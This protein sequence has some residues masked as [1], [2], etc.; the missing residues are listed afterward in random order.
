MKNIIRENSIVFLGLGNPGRDVRSP[1][2]IGAHVCAKITD[3]LMQEEKT[4]M[5]IEKTI[6]GE[7][8]VFLWNIDYANLT[9]NKLVKFFSTQETLRNIP[10]VV[11]C[12]DIDIKP[13]KWVMS[14]GNNSHK[15]HNGIKNINIYKRNYL[16][17]RIGTGRPANEEDVYQFVLEKLNP[18][19]WALVEDAIDDIIL[20]LPKLILESKNLVKG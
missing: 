8:I 18:K 12:D 4:C 13:G 17:V 7:D 16:K 6:N 9:G 19:D 14:N 3:N 1:H 10:M 11:F 5:F 2:N 15:G 20:Q